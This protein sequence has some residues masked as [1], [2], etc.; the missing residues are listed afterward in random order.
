MTLDVLAPPFASEHQLTRD[1]PIQ[2]VPGHPRITLDD[3]GGVLDFLAS[4]FCSDKDPKLHLVWNHDLIFI[5][6]LP[7]YIGSYKFWMDFLC[8]NSGTVGHGPRFRPAALGYLRT[9]YYLIRHESDLR[10]AQDPSLCLVPADVTWEQ[11]CNF[12][13]ALGAISDRDVSVRYANGEIRLSRLNFY[14]PLLL[15]KS[16]FQRVEYQYGTYFTRFFG[17]VLFLI[18]IMSVV[19][20][21]LQVMASVEQ[22]DVGSWIG[23]ARWVSVITILASS[24]LLFCLGGMF[25]YKVAKEWKFAIQTRRRL[26][27]ENQATV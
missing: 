17:P 20:S 22:G 3:K 6:P 10:I 26:M 21:G 18:G 2:W 13:S 1:E 8:L 19:L 16:Q 12:T 14:A 15:R 4:E 7:R 25:M 27:K 5:K 11:Y 23:L 9:Y 24:S